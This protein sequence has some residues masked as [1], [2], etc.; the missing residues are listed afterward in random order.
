MQQVQFFQRKQEYSLGDR[1]RQ[2]E[3]TRGRVGYLA[4]P[5]LAQLGDNLLPLQ[6]LVRQQTQAYI[7]EVQVLYKF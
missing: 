5:N 1:A 3:A 2:A 6:Q 7:A 4:S